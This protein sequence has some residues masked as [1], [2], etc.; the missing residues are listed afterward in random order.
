MQDR[1]RDVPYVQFLMLDF[2]SVFSIAIDILILVFK[3]L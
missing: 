1:N 2:T 3:M